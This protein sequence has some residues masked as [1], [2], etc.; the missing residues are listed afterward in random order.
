VRNISS[1]RSK[2]PHG[3]AIAALLA[4][5]A[6]SPAQAP[7]SGS[8]QVV[9]PQT[10]SGESREET[11]LTPGV[12]WIHLCREAPANPDARPA[13]G[14][15]VGAPAGPWSIHILEVARH[16]REIAVHSRV[17]TDREG[18]LERVPLTQLAARAR[19]DDE[20]VIAAVNG[21]YD[22][23]APQLGLPI[24]LAVSNGRIWSAGGPSRPAMAILESNIPMIGV[25]DSA[26]KLHV[27]DKFID[28]F[29]RVD[30]LNKPM[31]FS[32]GDNLRAYTRGFNTEV[33]APKPFRAI[34]VTHLSPGGPIQ[35]FGGL[36]GVVTEIRE[37]G[38]VQ[39][40]P[41]N[42][43]L[44]A[45]PP[46]VSNSRSVLKNFKVGQKVILL[47]AVSI[48]G[49][50]NI[51]EAIGGLPMLIS[52]GKISIEGEGDPGEYLKARHPRTAVCYTDDNFIFA[53]V[54]GRQP[55]LSV[56]MTLE[57]LADFMLSLGCKEA[58]NSDG[59]GS[60]ELAVALPANS[61][62]PSTFPPA[63][64]SGLTIVNS[65][66]DCNERGRPNAWMIIRNH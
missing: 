4:F 23:A 13:A 59:G 24:G 48:G 45:E 56:G 58:M 39:I 43:L 3:I 14:Q 52:G 32:L 2:A 55:K 11:E 40:I 26:L 15:P 21:D 6:A 22:F 57:E 33:K 7:Q 38:E 31:D 64:G 66:S 16:R 37:A 60:T 25:P 51:K 19:A 30:T 47:T 62:H 8:P 36:R 18:R 9:A 46:D 12:I 20:D 41:E 10:C 42:A 63:A 29:L 17:G 49:Q 50:V 65:P 34:V 1:F 35:I 61:T 53:V 54:D 27:K 44:L 28:K 5:C